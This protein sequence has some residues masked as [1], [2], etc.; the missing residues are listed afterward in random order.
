MRPSD[1]SR[2]GG[3]GRRQLAVGCGVWAV[4]HPKCA[5]AHCTPHSRTSMVLNARGGGL[6][7]AQCALGGQGGGQLEERGPDVRRGPHTH[8]RLATDVAARADLSSFW[9][10][11]PELRWPGFEQRLL[12]HSNKQAPPPVSSRA[13]SAPLPQGA[14]PFG[15]RAC[16]VGSRK[17]RFLRAAQ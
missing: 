6:R 5:A 13:A 14:V 9:T 7:G 3:R 4:C 17:S 12:L 10:A 2:T 8:A 11:W 1:S 16:K 15:I